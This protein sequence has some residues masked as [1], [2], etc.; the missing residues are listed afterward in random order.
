MPTFLAAKNG[1]FQPIFYL[2]E[3]ELFQNETKTNVELGRW[4]IIR[5]LFPALSRAFGQG[6]HRVDQ[7]GDILGFGE[8]VI[9]GFG[10]CDDNI[11]AVQTFND[12]Q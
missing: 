6:F 10:E 7:T 3:S 2:S 1:R 4:T 12:L 5:Q 8:A 11:V 9:A